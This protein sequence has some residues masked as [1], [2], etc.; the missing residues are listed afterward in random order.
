MANLNTTK[1]QIM[2][3]LKQLASVESLEGRVSLTY[4]LPEG[5]AL[6]AVEKFDKMLES[7]IVNGL[8]RD[9]HIFYRDG[10]DIYVC[11]K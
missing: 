9:R 5:N 10:L 11:S 8:S 2:K 6:E 1:K 3:A 7:I 4:E